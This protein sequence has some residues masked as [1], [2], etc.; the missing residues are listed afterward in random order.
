MVVAR[1]LCRR[2]LQILIF[3]SA[4]SLGSALVHVLARE[5]L[6]L[7]VRG[8]FGS[9]YLALDVGRDDLGEV[10][11]DVHPVAVVATVVLAH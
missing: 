9:A 3:L 11:R 7:S 1:F 8:V 6:D 2:I 4:L 5:S 10:W